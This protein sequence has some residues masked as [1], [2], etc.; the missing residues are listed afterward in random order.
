MNAPASHAQVIYNGGQSLP[1]KETCPDG[2]IE[3]HNDAQ[4]GRVIRV[5]VNERTNKNSERCEFA[6]GRGKLTE[7]MTVYVGWKSRI[8]VPTSD[9]RNWNNMFQL[10]CHGTHVAD[11]PLVFGV[12]GG[13]LSLTNHENI[14]GRETGRRVWSE[15][16]RE[17]RWFSIVLKIHYSTR[18]EVGYVRLWY[19]GRL[20]TLDNGRTVHYGQTW[21]GTD[22]NMHWGIYRADEVNG[23]QTHDV[24]RPRIAT[25]EREADPDAGGTSGGP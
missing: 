15:P 4:R 6:A 19:D 7:G 24:W 18:R 12:Q 3:W 5:R 20:Q 1:G 22:K 2:G 9:D 14:N 17:N 13:R 8:N 10:H 11:H 25:T 21:E 16:S 23:T